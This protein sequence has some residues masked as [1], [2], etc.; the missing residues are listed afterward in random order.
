M[1]TLS[2]AGVQAHLTLQGAATD[3]DSF[4]DTLAERQQSQYGHVRMQTIW[5]LSGRFRSDTERETRYQT[6]VSH[7]ELGKECACPFFQEREGAQIRA[8]GS[9]AVDRA[10]VKGGRGGVASLHCI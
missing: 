3:S 7:R 1:T 5:P 2:S 6:C 9:E 4:S 10:G 8:G